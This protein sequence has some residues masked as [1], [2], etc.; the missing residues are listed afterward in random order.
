MTV[1]QAIILAIVEGITEFLPIS[2]TGH[3]ALT[4]AILGIEKSAFTKL[5]IEN[6]QFG[7][8]I[9]VLILY[10]RKFIDFKHISFYLK[11]LVAFLPAAVVGLLL[12]KHIDKVLETPLFISVV[13]FLGGFLLLFVDKW[14]NKPVID[15][16]GILAQM[17]QEV[18]QAR[19]ES[20]NEKD[21]EDKRD[22]I[23][24]HYATA[25]EKQTSTAALALRERV[26]EDLAAGGR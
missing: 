5:F 12:K 17:D 3:M 18:A 1:I 13:L 22:A 8:I 4:S 7:T 6:I 11:L 21:F 25:L 20:P 24:A 2:S 14:F 15:R 19:S 23:W 9:S 10:W 26:L 16:E